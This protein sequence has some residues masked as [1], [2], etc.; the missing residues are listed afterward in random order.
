[1]I[2]S[3]NV[4]GSVGILTAAVHLGQFRILPTAE[5]G[6][7][8]FTPHARQTTGIGNFDIGLRKTRYRASPIESE[9]EYVQLN[10]HEFQLIQSRYCVKQGP[11]RGHPSST[12]IVF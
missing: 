7:L 8:S 9:K 2:T 11:A 10:Q 6:A 12:A 4:I 5:A 1:L 3:V